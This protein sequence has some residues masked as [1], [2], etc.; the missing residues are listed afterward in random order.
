M[1][2]YDWP[3]TGKNEEVEM[4]L[5]QVI[6]IFENSQLSSGYFAGEGM[7]AAYVETLAALRE[8]QKY[9]AIGTV[10]ECRAAMEKQTEKAPDIWGDGYADGAM[11]YDM[12]TCPGCGENFEIDSQKHRHCPECGQHILWDSWEEE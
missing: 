4:E 1:M 9:R 5:E 3:L 2:W 12:W 6:H 8:L 7:T 11:V 10:G